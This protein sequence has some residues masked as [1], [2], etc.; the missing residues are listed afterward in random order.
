M[1]RKIKI[2]ISKTDDGYVGYPLGLEGVVVGQGDTYDET[3][4][5]V[6]SAIKF[7]IQ[8]F[9]KKVITTHI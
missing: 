4:K 7:H 2:V 8:T 3:L 9:G 6:E 5:D 1:I